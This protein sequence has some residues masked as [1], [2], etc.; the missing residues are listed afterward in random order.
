MDLG[1]HELVHQR[2]VQP[3][4]RVPKEQSGPGPKEFLKPIMLL[5]VTASGQVSSRLG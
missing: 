2:I 3:K 4:K 1:R 5:V